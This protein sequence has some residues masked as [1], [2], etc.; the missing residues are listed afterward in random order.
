MGGRRPGSP[1]ELQTP[2]HLGPARRENGTK[3]GWRLRLLAVGFRS[4]VS[5]TAET[6][7]TLAAVA[8]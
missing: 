2:L 6:A 1:A 4:V 8:L 3:D 5:T 7:A